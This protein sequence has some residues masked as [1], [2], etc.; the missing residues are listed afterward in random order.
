VFY[1]YKVSA[2][3]LDTSLGA[4]KSNKFVASLISTPNE[5][6]YKSELVKEYTNVLWK[7]A[8]FFIIMQA[9]FYLAF[10]VL[11]SLTIFYDIETL[12]ILILMLIYNCVFLVYELAEVL[13]SPKDY[14][15]DTW[16]MIDSGRILAAGI[17]LMNK[18]FFNGLSDEFETFCLTMA[19][20][21]NWLRMI[22]FYRLFSGTR[23][24]IRMIIEIVKGMAPFLV[25][26]LSQVATMTISVAAMREQDFEDAWEVIYRLSY[27]NFELEYVEHNERIMFMICSMVL[28][29]VMLNL[30]IA[31]MGDKYGRVQQRSAIEDERERLLW[32]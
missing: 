23:Y 7:Q 13:I 4:K 16:N 31:I 17:Y 8:V 10:V 21:L 6:I 12:W 22:S 30:I 19:I 11:L 28:T 32:I 9:M 20:L 24:L 5:E 15:L 26:F 25:I 1:D 27:A 14:R 18:A 29:L 3:H 2:I